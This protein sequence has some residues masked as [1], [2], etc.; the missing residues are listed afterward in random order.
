MD[1]EYTRNMREYWKS[2]R[3]RTD[4]ARLNWL[5]QNTKPHEYGGMFIAV[6]NGTWEVGETTSAGFNGAS[7][8][9]G[10]S[11]RA[12]IDAAMETP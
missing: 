3:G 4:T 10:T 5:E 6:I 8:G 1:D 9:E 7:E 12:A 2:V 11:L